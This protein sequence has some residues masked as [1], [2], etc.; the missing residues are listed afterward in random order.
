MPHLTDLTLDGG[1][2]REE[3]LLYMESQR[4]IH[5]GMCVLM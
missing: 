1:D 3:F 4:I 5:K 2:L